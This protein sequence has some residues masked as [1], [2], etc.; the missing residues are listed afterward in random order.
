MQVRKIVYKFETLTTSDPQCS[1]L[2][3]CIEPYGDISALGFSKKQ[4]EIWR[5]LFK[6]LYKWIVNE[7]VGYR[8]RTQMNVL[9]P[10]DLYTET[11]QRLK[12]KHAH[13]LVSVW[14]EKTDP[15]KFVYEDIAIASWLLCLW[16]PRG[17]GIDQ[18][19]RKIWAT[20]QKHAADLRAQTIL[21]YE[22]RFDV[23]WIIGNHSDELSPWLMH[24]AAQP[25]ES[26]YMLYTNYI[27]CL[28]EECGYNPERE[29]LR[30]PSPK[31][32]AVVGRST[33]FDQVAEKD[34]T[35]AALYH[36]EQICADASRSFAPR[37]PDSVKNELRM[38]RQQEREPV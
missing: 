6:K 38:Q 18:C 25:G 30:I 35:R 29:F 37:I 3:I 33:T 7:H 23:D 36:V 26:K 21:P 5:S 13:W 14:T 31:N 11:Y 32:V 15:Q 9:V 8:K 16:H 27:K 10:K 22:T 12:A 24:L 2:S 1:M 34:R 17:Y 4:Q 19:S 28:S 20:F